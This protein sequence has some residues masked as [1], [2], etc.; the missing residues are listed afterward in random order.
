MWVSD[1][2][3]HMHTS[4]STCNIDPIQN[5]MTQA[6][7]VCLMQHNA[8]SDRNHV[9]ALVWAFASS[10]CTYMYMYLLLAFYSEPH[11][12][13]SCMQCFSAPMPLMYMYLQCTCTCTWT[14]QKAWPFKVEL[15][16]H[17]RWLAWIKY[18]EIKSLIHV[19]SYMRLILF[20]HVRTMYYKAL[21]LYSVC[22]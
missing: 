4:T 3:A 16:V 6:G 2:Y 17:L 10:T 18:H 20:I 11:S 13:H 5:A 15:P 12:A 9:C 22:L 21:S 1:I 19:R 14:K 8:I 7:D